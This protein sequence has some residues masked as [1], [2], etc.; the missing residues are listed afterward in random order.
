VVRFVMSVNRV[1]SVL[2]VILD[3]FS[4]AGYTATKASFI[5]EGS[6]KSIQ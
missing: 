6:I 1:V 2:S 3:A 4:M 5:Y